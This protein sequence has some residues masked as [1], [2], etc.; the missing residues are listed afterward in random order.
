MLIKV[1][2][3]NTNPIVGLFVKTGLL[4]AASHRLTAQK[5]VKIGAMIRTTLQASLWKRTFWYNKRLLPLSNYEHL[6]NIT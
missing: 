4:F 5:T 6:L 1:G 2:P 3:A